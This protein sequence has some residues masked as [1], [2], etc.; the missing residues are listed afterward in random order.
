M[1]PRRR[2]RRFRTPVRPF[3]EG[4][5]TGR[6][7]LIASLAGALAAPVAAQQPEQRADRVGYIVA[8]VGDSAILNFDLQEGI[9]GRAAA[10]RQQPPEPGSPEY[11]QLEAIVLEDLVAEILVLQDALRDTTITV[12][13]DQIARAVQRQIEHD[14]QQLGRAVALEQ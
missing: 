10:A 11:A 7:I 13:D 4:I 3:P 1:K 12:P 8:I 5:M 9:I 2:M 6:L 14:H